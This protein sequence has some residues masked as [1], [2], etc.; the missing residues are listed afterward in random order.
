MTTMRS[1]MLLLAA[2]ACLMTLVSG[3]AGVFG[4]K[5]LDVMVER[6][7]VETHDHSNAMISFNEANLAYKTQIYHLKNIVIR[8]NDPASYEKYAQ[9]FA[10][11]EKRVIEMMAQ[12]RVA[13][14][15][16]NMPPDIIKKLDDTVVAYQLTSAAYTDAVKQFDVQ[17]P[18][19]GKQT[20]KQVRGKDRETDKLM[21]ELQESIVVELREQFDSLE[22]SVKTTYET[23]RNIVIVL[24]LAGLVVVMVISLW[25]MRNVL[26]TLGGEPALIAQI[27]ARVADGDLVSHG[28]GGQAEPDSVLGSIRRMREGVRTIVAGIHASSEELARSAHDMAQQSAAVASS[29]IKQGEAVASMAAAMEEMATSIA[30]VADNANDAQRNASEAGRLSNEGTGV[31]HEASEEMRGIAAT[32]Q[33]ATTQIQS[34][35]EQSAKISAIVSVIGEIA[36]QTNLLALNAAIEAARAG[37]QGRGFA[38][39]AD[40]VRK[41]AERTAQS[42]HEISAMIQA[43]HQGTESA[44]EAMNTGNQRVGAGVDKANKAAEA[45]GLIKNGSDVVLSAVDDISAALSEQRSTTQDVARSVENV[46]RMNE[47]NIL[48]VEAVAAA[49][50]QVEG[51]ARRL[52]EDAQRFRIQ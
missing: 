45:I 52:K 48:A 51:I 3:M 10:K 11:S 6:H 32:V 36:D 17:D 13:M 46:A 12:A 35:E 49:A 26:R 7:I 18:N 50:H 42:T 30:Q 38:V 23:T 27:V 28:L 41:L 22:S 40:E 5:W 9:D 21:A 16:A 20:D 8:G 44:V 37:E 31:I 4:M 15:K 39:V 19:A 24:V 14:V 2:I 47:D 25:I 1:K 33:Q 34:L 43:V 29:N